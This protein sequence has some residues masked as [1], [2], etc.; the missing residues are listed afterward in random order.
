MENIWYK[1]RTVETKLDLV[2]KECISKEV[3]GYVMI[4]Y[5][6]VYRNTRRNVWS[7]VLDTVDDLKYDKH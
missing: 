7:V 6:D 1:L 3:D 5:L 2:K 4:A